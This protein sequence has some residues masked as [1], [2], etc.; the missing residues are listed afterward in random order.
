MAQWTFLSNHARVLL[1]LARQPDAR[2]R[3]IAEQIGVTERTVHRIVSE[4]IENDYV[5]ALKSGRRNSYTVRKS[6]GFR[7]PQEGNH[8]VGELIDM[9]SDVP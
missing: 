5:E 2:L 3:D 1:V 4:L 8:S 7:H 9:L 6:S